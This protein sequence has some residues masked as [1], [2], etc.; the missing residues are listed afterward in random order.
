MLNPLVCDLNR[1]RQTRDCMEMY[2]L[3]GAC[4]V[5]DVSGY[6]AGVRDFLRGME[7]AGE[8]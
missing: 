5:S 1:P 3:Y 4:H 8:M 6:E 2:G 7:E